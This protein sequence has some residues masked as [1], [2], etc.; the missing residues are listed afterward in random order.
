MNLGKR[1][2]SYNSPTIGKAFGF[3]YPQRI[4]RNNPTIKAPK[5]PRITPQSSQSI[6]L[7]LRLTPPNTQSNVFILIAG[8]NCP[9][10]FLLDSSNRSLNSHRRKQFDEFT[11]KA[12]NQPNQTLETFSYDVKRFVQSNSF[13]VCSLSPWLWTRP[14]HVHGVSTVNLFFSLSFQLPCVL[15]HLILHYFLLTNYAW[16]LCEGFYLHTVLV[17]AFISEQK[18]VKWLIALGWSAPALFLILYGTLR[19][20]FSEDHDRIL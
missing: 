9:W 19:A 14:T 1:I 13:N 20:F 7:T 15:L 2:L 18:L 3:D 10:Y 5:L 8:G 12:A 16:M 6:P 17:S 11:T 4:A